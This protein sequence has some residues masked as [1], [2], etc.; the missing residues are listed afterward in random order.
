MHGAGVRKPPRNEPAGEWAPIVPRTVSY[1]ALSAA[2]DLG[3][4]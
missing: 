4:R 1:E 3:G 2:L